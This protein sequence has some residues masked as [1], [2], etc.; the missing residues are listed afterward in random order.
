MHNQHGNK[1]TP[2]TMLAASIG[3][4]LQLAAITAAAQQVIE[5][6][7]AAPDAERPGA[8]VDLGVLRQQAAGLDGRAQRAASRQRQ[9]CLLHLPWCGR[10]RHGDSQRI[11]HAAAAP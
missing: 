9:G 5:R 8:Q 3:L 4:A 11:A 6:Q 7:L 2:V 1:K 10:I